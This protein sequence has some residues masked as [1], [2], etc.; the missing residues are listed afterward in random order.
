[1][2]INH[3]EPSAAKAATEEEEKKL[4]T[5]NAKNTKRVGATGGRPSDAA[6]E[7]KVNYG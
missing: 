2:E 1:L 4:A 5:K 7:P 6:I 3:K